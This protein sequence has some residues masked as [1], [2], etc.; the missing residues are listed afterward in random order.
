MFLLLWLSYRLAPRSGCGAL[1]RVC[2]RVQVT[3]CSMRSIG[4]RVSAN[5][6]CERP[7]VRPALEGADTRVK[8]ASYHCSSDA[9]I[10]TLAHWYRVLVK[11]AASPCRKAGN[12]TPGCKRDFARVAPGY[13]SDHAICGAAALPLTHA[14]LCIEFEDCVRAR[15][16]EASGNRCRRSADRGGGLLSFGKGDRQRRR[17]HHPGR[18]R[19]GP[20]M[21]P[22]GL[23]GI[24]RPLASIRTSSRAPGARSSRVMPAL[25]TC[26]LHSQDH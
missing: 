20:S 8:A 13:R 16:P 26:R 9:V 14:V 18:R 5:S 11:R 2:V 4:S 22:T 7:G 3:A 24:D 17:R 6:I 10:P 1:T 15:S 25:D 23:P 21:P 12:G 19:W